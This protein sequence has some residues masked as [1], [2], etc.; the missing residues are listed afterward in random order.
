MVCPMM[1]KSGLP[2]PFWAEAIDTA[3]KIRNSLPTRSLN[4]RTPYELWFNCRRPSIRHF[5]QFGC[6]AYVHVPI[7]NIGRSNK[8]APRSIRCCYLG[9]IGTKI[10]RLWDPMNKRI[11]TSRDVVFHENQFLHPSVFGNIEHSQ[12]E[13]QTPFDTMDDAEPEPANYIVPPHPSRPTYRPTPATAATPPTPPTAPRASHAQPTTSSIPFAPI[14]RPSTYEFTDTESDL[15]DLPTTP[16][17]SRPASPVSEA[18]SSESQQIADDESRHDE[19]HHDEPLPSGR[20]RR[21]A[22]FPSCNTMARSII[23]GDGLSRCQ[24]YMDP[25]SSSARSQGHRHKTSFPRQRRRNIET[26]F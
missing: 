9:I 8:V 15:E 4:G 24:R 3:V 22:T 5:R 14:P 18:S 13:F 20:H 16:I 2:T 10:Y 26:T 7:A 21:S 1:I 11:V 23:H 19:P 17:Q 6:I 12:H 25:R